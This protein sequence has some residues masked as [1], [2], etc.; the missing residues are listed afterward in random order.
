MGNSGSLDKTGSSDR[1]GSIRCST[2]N[3]DSSRVSIVSS[4]D[5]TVSTSG[6]SE[7][8]KFAY[9]TMFAM[10]VTTY[11]SKSAATCATMKRSKTGSK[12]ATMNV[13]QSKKIANCATMNAVLSKTP[14]CSNSNAMNCP[15]ARPMNSPEI[16]EGGLNSKPARIALTHPSFY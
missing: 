3:F 8:A 4:T 1:T 15:S 16:A 7:C 9:V 12:C 11:P 10:C 6:S 14:T 13:V 2:D 5:C